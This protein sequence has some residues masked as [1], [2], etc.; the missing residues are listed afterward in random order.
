MAEIKITT[1]LDGFKVNAS[2]GVMTPIAAVLDSPD[3][4]ANAKAN[5]L[6]YHKLGLGTEI[7]VAT[8]DNGRKYLTNEVGA[9]IINAIAK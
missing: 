7:P 8:M 3:F 5:T 2:T 4:G 1:G 6:M 9:A